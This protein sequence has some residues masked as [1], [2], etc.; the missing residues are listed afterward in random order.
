M[1]RCVQ[2]RLILLVGNGGGGGYGPRGHRQGR[3][4]RGRRDP[5]KSPS[6][7][8]P[9]KRR[10]P[11]REPSNLVKSERNTPE[12]LSYDSRSS[13]K[14]NAGA[15]SESSGYGSQRQ[16]RTSSREDLSTRDASSPSG[17]GFR[18]SNSMT[19]M[20]YDPTD[21]N[22]TQH[23]RKLSAPAMD[24][25]MRMTDRYRQQKEREGADTGA[26]Y[27][28]SEPTSPRRGGR[29]T[30]GSDPYA[31]IDQKNKDPYGMD[32]N[33]DP[34][35]MD[36]S[37][38]PYGKDP[39]GMDKNK[40]PYGKDPYGVDKNK[41]PYAKD[42]YGKDPYGV[43]KNKDP[44]G[45]DKNKDPY[46]KDPYGVDKSKDPYGKDPYGMDKNKDPY[47]MDKNKDPYSSKDP[48]GNKASDPA[49]T[50]PAS[51]TT[52]T[53]AND[54]LNRRYDSNNDPILDQPG[55]RPSPFESAADPSTKRSGRR[56]YPASREASPPHSPNRSVFPQ[57]NLDEMDPYG[58]IVS[59]GRSPSL[60]RRGRLSRDA[61][62][63]RMHR[64]TLSQPSLPQTER[65][66]DASNDPLSQRSRTRSNQQLPTTDTYD[67][68][69]NPQRPPTYGSMPYGSENLDPENMEQINNITQSINAMSERYGGQ[70]GGQAQDPYS[71]TA[72]SEASMYNQYDPTSM[73]PQQQIPM[74][75]YQ[76]PGVYG[77]N[78]DSQF[79]QQQQGMYGQ[80]P[81]QYPNQSQY[82]P[83]FGGNPDMSMQKGFDQQQQMQHPDQTF[84]GMDQYGMPTQYD[85][86][87]NPIIL[88][89]MEQQQLLQQQQ[90]QQQQQ[91]KDQYGQV[92]GQ[93][94]ERD[95]YGYMP[96]ASS[97][98]TAVSDYARVHGS[99]QQQQQGS[100]QDPHQMP[101]QHPH[102]SPIR[103]PTSDA[104]TQFDEVICPPTRYQHPPSSH[105]ITQTPV[106]YTRSQVIQ[107]QGPVINSRPTQTQR[108]PT[109]TQNTQ[110]NNQVAPGYGGGMG[111]PTG[112]GGAMG[113]YNPEEY[114]M[115]IRDINVELR[116]RTQYYPKKGG[117]N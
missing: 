87:G 101:G 31:S 62:P 47:G 27:G 50:T 75:D 59:K 57:A 20:E 11:T 58:N 92:T 71:Q 113:G 56:S 112:G 105:R 79:Q 25:P 85:Q 117:K 55:T 77:E 93:Y 32:K 89:E 100:A 52:T 38:D 26:G 19:S 4:D 110:T 102:M 94:S 53:Y 1:Y 95:P 65:D 49:Y 73:N 64:R 96:R 13:S 41:D 114:T 109:V 69:Q 34:Y 104:Q 60:S 30:P 98:A 35:G 10:E 80:N 22:S 61:S 15:A 5:R 23:R 63:E 99:G 86:F 46:G 67:G 51:Q 54:A 17:R 37:K 81:N 107:T 44:Y 84:G 21:R 2:V 36:K 108:T 88:S 28:R 42:P 6:N 72:V 14:Y 116:P 33:K 90:Q 40:D 76:R 111:G 66:Y 3:G 83:M 7:H 97:Q 16:S 39:Y 24:E 91:Q 8:S 78:I 12:T 68:T 70:A 103:V 115:V 9:N 82:D 106:A 45:M 43:D 18:S 29:R 74:S 48:Y